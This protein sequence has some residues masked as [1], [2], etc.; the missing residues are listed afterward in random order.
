MRLLLVDHDYTFPVDIGTWKRSTTGQCVV[1][2]VK[3]TKIDTHFIVK[4]F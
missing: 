4:S 3:V 1:T 2:Q